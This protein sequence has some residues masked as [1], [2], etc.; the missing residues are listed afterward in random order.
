[1]FLANKTKKN[2]WK[3]VKHIKLIGLECRQS[4]NLKN[5]ASGY[6]YK[7]KCPD[8]EFISIAIYG[9]KSENSKYL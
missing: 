4:D 3:I 8:S 2:C 5:T 7:I 6:L 1:M 9:K